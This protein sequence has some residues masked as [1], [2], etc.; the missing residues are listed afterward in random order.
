MI[1]L[2]FLKDHSGHCAGPRLEGT[3]FKDGENS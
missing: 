3:G 1:W 2:D